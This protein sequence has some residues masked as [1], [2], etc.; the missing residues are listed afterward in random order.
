MGWAAALVL[1]ACTDA[2]PS[3]ESDNVFLNLSSRAR[4]APGQDTL[5]AGWSSSVLQTC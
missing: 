2:Y 5:I 3:S 1:L 4:I